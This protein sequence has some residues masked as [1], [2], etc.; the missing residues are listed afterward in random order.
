MFQDL[1]LTWD[2]GFHRVSLE[3]DFKVVVDM[4][5]KL[6]GVERFSGV[7]IEMCLQL[8]NNDYMVE[9]AHI[10]RE[11]NKVADWLARW[12]LKQSVGEHI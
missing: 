1:K 3:V 5:R 7:L 8:I 12:A 9:I 4:L 11:A 2:Y 6:N 10:Y